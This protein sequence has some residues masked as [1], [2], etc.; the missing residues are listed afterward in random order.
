MKTRKIGLANYLAYGAGDFLGAGTTALTAAWLLYFYTTF[1][2]LTPIEATLI[3]AAARVLDAV[4]SP[5]MGFLTDN[6]GTTWLGKRFGRRKF[7]ILLGIPCVFSYSAMW[8]GEMGFWYYLATY[9]LFDMVYTMILVPYETLVPEMTDDFK[10]K[11]KFS[12]ARISMAQM[13]AILASFLPGILLSWLGK[14]NAS[15][16]FYAS[17]VF[18]VLCAVMLTL[19]WC[20]TWERPREAWSEAAL[21]AEAEKQNL[22]LAQ[23]L[24]RLVIEL[25]STLRIKIFRRRLEPAGDDGHLPVYCSN[26]HDPA[27]HSFWPRAVVPHGGGP[28]WPELTLLRAALLRRTERRLFLIAAHLCCRRTGTRRDKLRTVEYLHLYCRRRR[29]DHRP[30][31]GGDFCRHHDSDPQSLAGG[32]GDAGGDHYAVVGVCFRAKNTA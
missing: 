13:S 10:Q 16:F 24:N 7:F 1:C 23:S 8:V 31:P 12:G 14:D 9:L 2:G 30:A 32:G 26:R 25:S 6:F 22:T 11:T 27:V 29:S 21:R 5:L 18:S 17:L 4:V 28:V 3:F 19:V 20:F 15:S